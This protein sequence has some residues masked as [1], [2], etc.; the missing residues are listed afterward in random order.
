MDQKAIKI[1]FIYTQ[2]NFK[3]LQTVFAICSKIEISFSEKT[4]EFNNFASEPITK[5]YHENWKPNEMENF[6]NEIIKNT[7][8]EIQEKIK[9][10]Q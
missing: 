9:A 4:L 1:Q 5:L 7:M 10:N 2:S 3:N 6:V 8:Q